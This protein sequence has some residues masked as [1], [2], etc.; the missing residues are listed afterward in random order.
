M[1][2]R[3]PDPPLTLVTDSIRDPWL[4]LGSGSVDLVVVAILLLA[5]TVGWC[6]A[7]AALASA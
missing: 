1:K 5:S 4:G 7:P 6:Q 3:R 2:G